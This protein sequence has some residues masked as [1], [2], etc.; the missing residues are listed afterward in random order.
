MCVWHDSFIRAIWLNYACDTTL[1]YAWHNSFIFATQ[2]IRDVTDSFVWYDSSICVTWLIHVCDA[3]H[4]YMWLSLNTFL[5]CNTLQHTATHCNTL[6]H[7]ATHFS[8]TYVAFF[9]QPTLQI[10]SHTYGYTHM[11]M[12]QMWITHSAHIWIYKWLIP[13]TFWYTH[14]SFR[15]HMHMNMCK[16]VRCE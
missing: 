8:R 15:T 12:S 7:S 10:S 1:A 11:W 5:P 16:R 2:L 9:E 3:L 13:H 4:V 14:D 6:Q